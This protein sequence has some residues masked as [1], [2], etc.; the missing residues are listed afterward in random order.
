MKII[1]N[2][3]K[4]RKPCYFCGTHKSVKYMVE[5]YI[6]ELSDEP[7]EVCAC[8]KCALLNDHPTEKGGSE[9]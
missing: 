7:F 9:E 2:W 3:Q 1:P 5:T 4:N 6:L 8:N